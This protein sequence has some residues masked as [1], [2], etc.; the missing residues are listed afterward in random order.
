MAIN[1][2][3]WLKTALINGAKRGTISREMVVLRAVDYNAK[4]Q[5]TDADMEAV[6]TALSA[7]EE[8]DAAAAAAEEAAEAVTEDME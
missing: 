3:D 8:A 2:S 6:Y 1:I 7:L 4:G 5:M